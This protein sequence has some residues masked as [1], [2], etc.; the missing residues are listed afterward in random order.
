MPK[1]RIKSYAKRFLEGV[2]D[3]VDAAL[4]LIA[5]S[6]EAEAKKLMS[7]RKH[8]AWYKVPGTSKRYQAS[9]PGEAPAV[10]TGTLRRRITHDLDPGIARVG[11]N[12][13]YH[14]FLEY[15]TKHMSPR[16]IL[17][18]ALRRVSRRLNLGLRNV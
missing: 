11:S 1:R 6:T 7:G 17:R 3:E 14:R 18:P 4:K 8:G 10:R 12:V 13:Q 15:G 9:A 5:L 16:P 2:K